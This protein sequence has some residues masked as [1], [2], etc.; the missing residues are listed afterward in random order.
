MPLI[1]VH[2]TATPESEVTKRLLKR[3]STVLAEVTGKPEKWV[4]TRLAPA[5]PMTFGGSDAPTAYVEAKSLGGFDPTQSEQLSERVC[6]AL[7]EELGLAK[8]R[9]Y[10]EMSDAPRHL[11]GWN[12]GTFA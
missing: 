10:I 2:T 12:G 4:M 1:H 5:A 8:D 6:A 9:V 3:L 7:E 11:W